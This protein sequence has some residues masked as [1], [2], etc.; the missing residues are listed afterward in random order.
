MS[1][2]ARALDRSRG[3]R[4]PGQLPLHP[5][6]RAFRWSTP[7]GTRRLVDDE[8][9]R[10]W[11]ELGYFLLREAFTAAEVAAVRAEIDPIEERVA[12]VL[13]E[14]PDRKIFIAEDGNITFSTQLVR[15]SPALRRFCH[16]RVFR[17]LAYDLIGPDVRLYWDQA[18]Y[19]KP[20]RPAASR[21][22]RTTA[23]PTSSRSST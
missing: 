19:K 12:R 23:T 22:T 5:R 18:V 15:H 10:A 20:E 4:P 11:D 7:S 21:G 6:N 16:H 17:D 14:H 2:D 8:Q 9:A 13:R 3:A 1:N